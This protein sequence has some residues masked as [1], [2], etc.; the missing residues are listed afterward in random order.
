MFLKDVCLEIEELILHTVML[1]KLHFCI[2]LLWVSVSSTLFAP[3]DFRQKF[4]ALF[5]CCIC[6]PHLRLTS[7]FLI[8]LP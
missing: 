2:N 3:L 4:C 8:L 5:S 6:M 1:L 7:Q